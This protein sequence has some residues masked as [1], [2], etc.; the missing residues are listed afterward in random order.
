MADFNYDSNRSSGWG[1]A[2]ASNA[3]G[4]IQSLTSSYFGSKDRA[5]R[6]RQF[7]A[8]LALKQKQDEY[9]Q[10]KFEK[11]FGLKEQQLQNEQ[12]Y[13]KDYLRLLGNKDTGGVGSLSPGQ[14]ELDK[15][16]AKI[17]AEEQI[18]GGSASGASDIE[19]LELAKK[20]LESGKENLTGGLLGVTPGW[21]KKFT[22]PEALDVQQNVEGIVQKNLKKILGAQFTENEATLFLER[23][24]DPALPEE[25]NA[26]RIQRT[27]DVLK[28]MASAKQG[29]SDYFSKYGTL[30]GYK[31]PNVEEIKNK[32]LYSKNENKKAPSGL[33]RDAVA[34]D[35]PKQVIQNG[36]TYILNEQTGQYE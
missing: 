10:K 33:L 21:I 35:K 4:L 13:K 9:A 5:E 22:N 20:R 7:D 31:G 23:A 30:K 29:A 15:A 11:E 36:H 25:L 28:S 18:A 2:V 17:I 12:D 16:A 26:K 24:Y 27:V 19:S 1:G 34:K 3:P 14:K 6:K 8:E 32:Y